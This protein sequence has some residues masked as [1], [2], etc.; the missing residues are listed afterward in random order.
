M[1]IWPEIRAGNKGNRL[2]DEMRPSS[3]ASLTTS[4]PTS[5]CCRCGG[6]AF[7]GS[8]AKPAPLGD[9]IRAVSIRP[10]CR[11]TARS[12]P[13]SIF[14]PV[15]IYQVVSAPASSASSFLTLWRFSGR[16]INLLCDA[17]LDFGR[18]FSSRPRCYSNSCIQHSAFIILHS[19]FCIHHSAFCI[20]HSAFIILHSSFC[21]L[22][23]LH[24]GPL[25]PRLQAQ[26]GKLHALGALQ[27]I[28]AEGRILGHVAEEQLP[29][30]LEGVV[31]LDT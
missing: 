31:V 14:A 26:L 13:S 6:G 16:V 24:P 21:Q 10:P 11:N 28:P 5:G 2:S 25:L 8:A 4:F 9:R 12:P 15:C 23:H 20:H 19:S 30:G 7:A 17:P 22:R 1:Q 27:K 29:L 3:P 18:A